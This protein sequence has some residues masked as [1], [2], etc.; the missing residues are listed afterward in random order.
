MIGSSANYDGHDAL[1]PLFSLLD[2]SLATYNTTPMLKLFINK[3]E[4]MLSCDH[5]VLSSRAGVPAIVCLPSLS[6]AEK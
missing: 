2:S 5:E 1:G 4:S 6:C 3:H